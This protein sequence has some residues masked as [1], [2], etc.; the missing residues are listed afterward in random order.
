MTKNEWRSI[1]QTLHQR[2]CQLSGNRLAGTCLLCAARPAAAHGLCAACLAEL[3][4]PGRA[5]PQCARP[6]PESAPEGLICGHCQRHPPSFERALAGLRHEQGARWLVHALKHDKRLPAARPLAM[7]LYERLSLSPDP[8]PERLIPVPLHPLRLVER[9]FNQAQEIARE[10]AR[11]L[12]GSLP[13]DPD[14]ARRVRNTAHQTGLDKAQ[15]RR[16]PREAFAFTGP[17]PPHVALI[18]DVMTTGATFEALARAA[19]R[20]GAQRVEVW[21]A[22][23]AG[24][25]P[26]A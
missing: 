14:C 11:L 13:L 16:N 9:G 1:A 26:G 20:A 18:D 7:A 6:L 22:T 21:C 4:R 23:R 10:L 25:T 12:A 15:R 5:C 17:L 19:R 3:P 2:T 8:L 24:D